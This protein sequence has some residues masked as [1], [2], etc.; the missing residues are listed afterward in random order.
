MK[1]K[2]LIDLLSRI[3]PDLDVYR[4]GYE[5]G[6]EDVN[7][8]RFEDMVRNYNPEDEWWYGP[9]ESKYVCSLKESDESQEKL[10]TVVGV[11][12]V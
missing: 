6:Y 3:D 5:G 1:V 2:E 10:E 7:N 11:L 9:H 4:P 12:L 8:I